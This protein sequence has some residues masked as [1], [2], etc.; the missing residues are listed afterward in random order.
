MASGCT[1]NGKMCLTLNGLMSNIKEL[2][3]LIKAKVDIL[4]IKSDHYT[5]NALLSEDNRKELLDT[6]LLIDE[7]IGK[8]RNE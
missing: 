3:L 7:L 6:L 1:E 2:V 5:W 8:L 4:K